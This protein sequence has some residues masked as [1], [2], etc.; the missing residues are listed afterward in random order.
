MKNK[1]IE[2]CDKIKK[3]ILNINFFV[4]EVLSFKN[5]IIDNYQSKIESDEKLKDKYRYCLYYLL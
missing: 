5:I 2:I 4:L 3:I 1:V